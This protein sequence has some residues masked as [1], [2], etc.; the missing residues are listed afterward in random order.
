MRLPWF[1]TKPVDGT[2]FDTAPLRLSDTFEIARPATDV[3]ADLTGESPLS[4]CRII[5][6]I[7]WTSPPP[8]GVGTT[9]TARSLRGASV[10][11]ERFFRWEEGR[12][13]SFYTVETSAPLFR[14]FAEDYVVEPVSDSSCR[15]TWTIAVEPRPAARIANPVNRRLLGTLF[16]DTRAHYGLS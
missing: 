16:T 13:Q 4:W 10:L 8:Y 11:K 9:R 2:F 15:F 7:S 12:R 14:R 6:D 1:T 5:Q 3:W